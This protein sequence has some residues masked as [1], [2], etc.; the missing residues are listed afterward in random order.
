MRRPKRPAV[1]EVGLR[2]G[3]KNNGMIEILAAE[4]EDDD[5]DV[6]REVNGAI[7]RVPEK[8][9]KLDFIDRIKQ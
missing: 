9:I 8:G 5:E 4:S 6:V 7:F 2:R 1:V 3:F